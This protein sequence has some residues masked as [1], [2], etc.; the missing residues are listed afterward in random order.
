MLSNFGHIIGNR[1]EIKLHVSERAREMA[2]LF[3]VLVALAEDPG[4]VPSTHMV[5]HNDPNSSSMESDTLF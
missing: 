3:R 2:G 1:L 4:S 5:A